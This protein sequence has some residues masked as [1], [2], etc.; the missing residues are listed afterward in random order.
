[1]LAILEKY[2]K[3]PAAGIRSATPYYQDPKGKMILESLADQ[4]RWF[5]ANG[6]M[7]EPVSVDHAVDLSFIK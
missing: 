1:M 5:V 3:V 2:T 4:I 6:L 7:K